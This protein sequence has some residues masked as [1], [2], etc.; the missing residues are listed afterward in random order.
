MMAVDY[1]MSMKATIVRVT[2]G[3]E[4]TVKDWAAYEGTTVEDARRKLNI[5]VSEGFLT[6]RSEGGKNIYRMSY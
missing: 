4:F 6:V 1:R 3:K 5:M 2:K